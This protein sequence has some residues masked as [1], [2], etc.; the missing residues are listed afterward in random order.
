MKGKVKYN[1]MMMLTDSLSSED[2]IEEPCYGRP[3][4]LIF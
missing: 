2:G 1:S 4:I 3:I